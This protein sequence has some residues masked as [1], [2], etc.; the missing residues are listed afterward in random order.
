[1]T[2]NQS[3]YGL[4]LKESFRDQVAS[5]YMF[6]AIRRE[7]EQIKSNARS[8]SKFDA[9]TKRTFD[10]V[11][12]PLPP[13]DIQK[14]L[15]DEVEQVDNERNKYFKLGMSE[16]EFD[17]QIKMLKAEIMDKYLMAVDSI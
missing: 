14:K 17:S 9:I 16:K 6:Y 4:R 10:E 15:V 11:R 13:K 7:V 12:I 3:N 1:M 8:S 2:F 5:G